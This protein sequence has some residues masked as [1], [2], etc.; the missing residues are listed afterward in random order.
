MGLMPEEIIN[1]NKVDNKEAAVDTEIVEEE[2]EE[3]IGEYDCPR[4]GYHITNGSVFC[5][6][7]GAQTRAVR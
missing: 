1:M 2:K 6:K 5:P 3:E 4:C 7:C